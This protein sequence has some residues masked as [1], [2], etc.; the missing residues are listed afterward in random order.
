[1]YSGNSDLIKRSS[2]MSL[3]HKAAKII[4]DTTKPKRELVNKLPP[5]DMRTKAAYIGCLTNP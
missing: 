1:M 5:T 2:R 4:V 3:H